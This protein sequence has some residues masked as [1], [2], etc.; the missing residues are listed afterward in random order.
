M[1]SVMLTSTLA[2]LLCA[3][4]GLAQIQPYV[5]NPGYWQYNGQPVLLFGG[6]GRDNIFQWAGEGTKLTDQLDLLAGCGGNYIRC[7]MSSREYAPGGF[8]WDLL[9]YPFA[10]VNGKYDLHQWDDAYW[11]KL[12]TF[13]AETK[14]RG[15]FVQLEFLDRWNESNNTGGPESGWKESPWNPDNNVTYDWDDSPL[16]KQGQ[17]GFYN[18]FHLAAITEDPV[19][20]PLQQ[21][22][23]EKVIDE[24]ID[25]G[26]DHVLFQVDNE[27][28]IG[29]DTLEPDPYWARYVRN[30]AQSKG[31]GEVFVCTSRRFH[32]PAPYLSTTFQ[33]WEN[34]ELR[35]PVENSAFNYYDISQNNGNSGQAHYDNFLWFRA[36][37]REHGVRPINNVKCY[38]MNWPTGTRW[39][40]HAPGTDAEAGAR[41][42]RVVFAGAASIRFH[43]DA[44]HLMVG[45]PGRPGFGLKPRA[46]AHIRSMHLFV[47]QAH[48]FTMEPH[49]DL[50][51]DRAEDEAYCLAEPGKQFAVFFTG[52]A[53]RSVVLDLSSAPQGLRLRWLDV[54]KSRWVDEDSPVR[55]AACTLRSPGPG[56]WVAVLQSDK[57]GRK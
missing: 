19:L 18:P 54:T 43:R 20:L 2:V 51:S 46:Q 8:R 26:N 16:L 32:P 45:R 22:F 55:G 40:Q 48:L 9:P 52:A 41:F 5:E 21:R 33:E 10:K 44:P 25:N 36:K 28:G 23:F 1:R 31:A 50:L 12:R 30:Y 7:T 3:G 27:S 37:V 38:H 49:N 57:G 53:D 13:L 4:Q 34:P 56:H 24:V 11:S 29:D 6:S 42:W 15:I 14:K 47:R 17:T 35:V 39:D